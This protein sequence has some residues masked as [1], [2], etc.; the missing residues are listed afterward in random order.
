MCRWERNREGREG[1]IFNVGVGVGVWR[2]E[3]RVGCSID[4]REEG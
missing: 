3:R 1:G 2:V 4:E